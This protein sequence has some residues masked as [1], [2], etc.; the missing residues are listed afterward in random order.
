MAEFDYDYV[1]VGSG[2][3]GSVSAMR[4]T[5]K[6]YKVGVLECGRRF[7]D[8][9]FA[10][11]SWRVRKYLW[12]PIVKC[13]GIFRM[14]LFKDVF[15][16]SGA[17]V[18]GGSLVY[19][20]TLYVPKDEVLNSSQW[21][22]GVNWRQ[23][24]MPNYRMAQFM[25]G[26]T[27]NQ[28]EGRADQ[29]MHKIADEM[30]KGDTYIRTPVGVHFATPNKT[31]PDPYFGGAG[32]DR[33]G[34]NYCGGC[35]IGCRFNAKNTLR[36]NY[37]YFAEKNGAEIHPMRTVVDV[38]PLEGGGYEITHERSGAW[39]FKNRKVTRA[40]NVVLSAGVLGTVKL[41]MKTKLHGSLP[42]LSDRLGQFVR[43]NSEAI[44]GVSALADKDTDYSRGIAITSSFHPED[45][46]HIE[47]VRYPKRSD[48]LAV[49]TTFMTDGEDA[50]IR[51]KMFWK[52]VARHPLNFLRGLLPFGWAEKTTI[53]LVMQSVDNTMRFTL[54]RHL[55]NG[56]SEGLDTDRQ[57]DKPIP[58]YIPVGNSVARRFA[59]IVKGHPRSTYMESLFDIP[60]T[61]HILGGAVVS[62]DPSEGVIGLDHQV[63]G[64]PG[65]YV[66]DGS[67]VPANLGVNPSLTITAMSERA[68]SHIPV[69]DGATPI[70]SIDP[71]FQTRRL[72]EIEALVESTGSQSL[73]APERSRTS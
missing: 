1:V 46:T 29:V 3:G 70:K 37:L 39:L 68:M 47:V 14:T 64:Y 31:I 6:G 27:Q 40:K 23:E 42:D 20:N 50:R 49:M 24:L 62:N 57:T 15:I 12:A 32:P 33:T 38:K 54:R 35:M 26:V 8:A 28:F 2:F 5:E 36:K 21:P 13:Y 48:F 41:L 10:K 67:A 25:L 55:L 17:G 63:H 69:K 44:I 4:L 30:G 22:Q 59:E 66:C 56:F 18:G 45:E 7:E 19:A 53:L 73:Q 72:Q 34:C 58:N 51:R 9:Q 43:T 65:L 16:L 11:S 61:A 60:T 71:D 52:L